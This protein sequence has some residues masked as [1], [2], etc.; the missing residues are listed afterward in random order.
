MLN[1]YNPED[2]LL[3]CKRCALLK[4]IENN[5]FYIRDEKTGEVYAESKGYNMLCSL[6][7]GKVKSKK[8]MKLTI[9]ELIKFKIGDRFV[10][11]WAKNDN[12][13]DVRIDYETQ[14]VSSIELVQTQWGER[15]EI[16]TEEDWYFGFSNKQDILNNNIVDGWPRNCCIYKKE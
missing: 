8:F 3:N 15:W 6:L 11:Y 14:T 9:A 10:V 13:S 5:T 4:D 1:I 7:E 12:S 2:L 16:H